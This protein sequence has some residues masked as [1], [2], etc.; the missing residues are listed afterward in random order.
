MRFSAK[1]NSGI[2]VFVALQETDCHNDC[3]MLFHEK[4]GLTAI[5]EEGKAAAKGF[6]PLFRS[7]WLTITANTQLTELGITAAISSA[8][9][10][11]GISC[12]MVA[13]NHHDHIFVPY[14]EGD[15]AC[16]ILEKL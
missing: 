16:A 3:V 1:I 7:E 14:G 8:L 12:N 10:D 6:A 2:Y 5:M 13:A 9:S 4:E 11:A 15:R